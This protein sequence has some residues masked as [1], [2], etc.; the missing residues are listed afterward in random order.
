MA[1]EEKKPLTFKA[2]FSAGIVAAGLTAA[3]V[4]PAAIEM[5]YDNI[6]SKYEIKAHKD[7]LSSKNHPKQILPAWDRIDRDSATGRLDTINKR[8]VTVPAYVERI[9]NKWNPGNDFLTVA[10]K[11]YRLS[12][13]DNETDSVYAVMVYEPGDSCEVVIKAQFPHRGSFA[14]TV[15]RK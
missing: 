12:F 3:T 5:Q 4:G 15:G 6:K 10:G 7:T 11:K 13:S 1:D 2:G 14:D 8:M 9:N